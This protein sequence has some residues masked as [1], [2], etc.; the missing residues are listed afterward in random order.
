MTPGRTPP[1]PHR[2]QHV[3]NVLAG[4]AEQPQ[5]SQL[6]PVLRCDPRRRTARGV[7]IALPGNPDLT[8]AGL[9]AA[10]GVCALVGLFARSVVAL[11][12]VR[13]PQRAPPPWRVL[14]GCSHSAM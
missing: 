3:M 8:G 10:P 2:H 7:R 13:G 11:V 4:T 9:R 1:R 6:G 5:H 14:A 12:A